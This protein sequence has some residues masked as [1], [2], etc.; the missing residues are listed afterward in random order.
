MPDQGCDAH[1]AEICVALRP[2]LGVDDLVVGPSSADRHP[3]HV[4]VSTALRGAGAGIVHTIWE[5]PTWAL[6]HGTAPAPT[7]TLELDEAAWHAKQHAIAAYRS[8]LQPLGPDTADG[9]V[10]HPSEL[11]V[12]LRRREEF[13]AVEI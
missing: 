3:D 13:L 1:R 12:M 10:V 2:L 4:A 5:A 11:T 8:Q 6:V 9:P 7:C